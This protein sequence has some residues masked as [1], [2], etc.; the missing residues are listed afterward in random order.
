MAEILWIED[1]LEI[2]L[3]KLKKRLE[4][5]H[6]VAIAKDDREATEEMRKR[7]YDL[8]IFDIRMKPGGGDSV[9]D[10]NTPPRKVGL[11]FLQALREGKIG[12]ETPSNVPVIVLT[13]IIDEDDKNEIMG[14]EPPP[15]AYL[16]KPV[17]PFEFAEVVERCLSSEIQTE[18]VSG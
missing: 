6:Q 15:L 11:K 17:D 3:E 18:R 2:G 13:A 4:E 12:G 10:H 7:R 14:V 1:Q 9:V 5:N 16:E 8:V